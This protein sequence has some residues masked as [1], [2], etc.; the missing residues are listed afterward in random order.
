MWSLQISKLGI[1]LRLSFL[2][3]RAFQMNTILVENSLRWV[4]SMLWMQS[5]FWFWMSSFAWSGSM[6]QTTLIFMRRGNFIKWSRRHFIWNHLL[7]K[8]KKR[9]SVFWSLLLIGCHLILSVCIQN[10]NLCWG[11]FLVTFK[12]SNFLGLLYS[13]FFELT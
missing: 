2:I 9:D 11:E 10:V 3:K 7:L 8:I 12:S 13:S 1:N 4:S 5:K 6:S